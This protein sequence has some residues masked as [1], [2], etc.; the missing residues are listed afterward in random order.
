M[1]EFISVY[2]AVYS[3]DGEYLYETFVGYAE[4]IDMQKNHIIAQMN[5]QKFVVQN[6]QWGLVF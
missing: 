5:G 3:W 2:D 6:G 1:K 4:L